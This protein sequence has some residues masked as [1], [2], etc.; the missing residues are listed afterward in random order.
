[1]VTRKQTPE[2]KRVTMGVK[3]SESEAEE[4]DAARGTANRSE[5]IR[6]VCLTAARPPGLHPMPPQTETRGQRVKSGPPPSKPVPP[7]PPAPVRFRE[8]EPDC[9]HPTSAV[10]KGRCT[11][12]R[13]FVGFG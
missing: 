9:I 5:W 13:T 1:M 6:E 4:I 11:R 10:I 3:F 8:A 12:C 2:G 7:P